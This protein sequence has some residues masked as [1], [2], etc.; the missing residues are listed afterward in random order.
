MKALL[1][2]ATGFIGKALAL[3]LAAAGWDVT[4][5]ARRQ[6]RD[7][8]PPGP[9]D[10]IEADLAEA[11]A[12]AG[13]VGGLT[14]DVVVHAGAIRNRWGTP[15][16]AYRAV[17]VTATQVLLDALAGRAGRFVYVSSVGVF[18]RP[19]VL[20][21]DEGFPLR[22][23]STWDYHSSKAAGERATLACKERIEAVV[24]RPTITY[25]PGDEDGMLTRLVQMVARRRFVRI[26]RGDNHVHLTYIDDLIDG[27]QLAMTHPQAPGGTF[28]LAGPEPIRM[29]DLLGLV[30]AQTGVELPG[31]Y[32]PARL[33][34]LAGAGCESL[35]RFLPGR[36]Q[37]P[38][39][40][41]KVDNLCANRSFSSARAVQRIDYRPR[42]GYAAGMAATY[43]WILQTHL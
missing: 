3:A 18:G 25:G 15:P 39:T 19:G 43:A 4:L 10:V 7:R 13:A 40:P 28:I 12:L 35:Y 27:L 26:G 5:L 41:D 34:R 11:A 33:A 20:G 32:V 1:T 30:E 2:G 21:I 9:F 17:N 23:A 16:E 22:V 42:W 38:I 24:V 36:W 8:L 6:S 37:P 29:R 14:V 31:W